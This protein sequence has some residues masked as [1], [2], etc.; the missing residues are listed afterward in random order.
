MEMMMLMENSIIDV[1]D[2]VAE[3][4]ASQTDGSDNNSCSNG[5]LL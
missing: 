2:V 4:D 5:W 3:G 1:D